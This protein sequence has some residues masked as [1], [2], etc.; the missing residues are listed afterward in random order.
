MGRMASHEHLRYQLRLVSSLKAGSSSQLY[1]NLRM[2]GGLWTFS[3]HWRFI[4]G[5]GQHDEDR[6]TITKSTW[7]TL[8][9]KSRTNRPRID[10]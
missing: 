3:N 1:I 8:R 5:Y 7:S 9:S 6:S 10:H 4:H 2:P